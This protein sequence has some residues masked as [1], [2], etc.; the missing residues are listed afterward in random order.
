MRWAEEKSKPRRPLTL[1]LVPRSS[2][3]VLLRP[4]SA[5]APIR[6]GKVCAIAIESRPEKRSAAAPCAAR[7]SAREKRGARTHSC[8][9]ET[10]RLCLVASA[11][12][13]REKSRRRTYECVRHACAD[14]R[15]TSAADC[16]HD[17]RAAGPWGDTVENWVFIYF[18]GPKAHDSKPPFDAPHF[19]KRFNNRSILSRE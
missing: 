6:I 18:C 4:K 8:R 3:R 2:S 5:A 11:N 15:P 1:T 7:S 9:A 16:H 13:R 12:K 19:S 14:G 10:R 17:R